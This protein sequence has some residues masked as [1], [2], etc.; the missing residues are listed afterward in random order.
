MCAGPPFWAG[1]CLLELFHW[2]GIISLLCEIA[3]LTADRIHFA[4]KCPRQE[5]A[6]T[7]R[8]AQFAPGHRGSRSAGPGSWPRL[9]NRPWFEPSPSA[10]RRRD[11]SAMPVPAAKE[12]RE[13][14]AE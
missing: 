14:H 2:G 4:E 13:A 5:L 7:A 1:A 10:R 3:F 6:S 12:R 11:R 9:P 8:A